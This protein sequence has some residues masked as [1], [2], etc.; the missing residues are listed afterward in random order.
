MNQFGRVTAYLSSP[1][2]CVHSAESHSALCI[3]QIALH[4]YVCYW[5]VFVT[6]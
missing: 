1:Y 2:W 6:I 4:A 3:V 5:Y